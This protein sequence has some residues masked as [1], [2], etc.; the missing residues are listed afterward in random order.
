M[1]TTENQKRQDAIRGLINIAL[2]EGAVLTLVIGVYL[3]TGEIVHLVGGVIGSTLIFTPMLLRWM[4]A[5]GAAMK[6]K[7]NSARDSGYE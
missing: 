5:H 1:D 7:P 3:Y 6:A 2:L 4:R